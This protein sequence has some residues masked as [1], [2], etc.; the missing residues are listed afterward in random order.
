[1]RPIWT[2]IEMR[3]DIVKNPG[4]NFELQAMLR[5]DPVAREVGLVGNALKRC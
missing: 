5:T 2:C 4:M 3:V 1:M